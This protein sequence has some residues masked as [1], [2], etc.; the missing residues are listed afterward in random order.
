MYMYSE[1]RQTIA[2]N[3][4]VP[5]SRSDQNEII[6]YSDM[7]KVIPSQ[8]HELKTI[9]PDYLKFFDYVFSNNNASTYL[10]ILAGLMILGSSIL[11]DTISWKTF[12]PQIV[13]LSIINYLFCMLCDIYL[14][15]N[16]FRSFDFWYN[17]IIYI[18]DTV[19]RIVYRNG[20]SEYSLVVQ[21]L[22]CFSSLLSILLFGFCISICDCAPK[23]TLFMRRAAAFIITIYC[24]YSLVMSYFFLE[25]SNKEICIL[26]YSC[27]PVSSVVRS[28]KTSNIIFLIKLVFHIGWYPDTMFFIQSPTCVVPYVAQQVSQQVAPSQPVERTRRSSAALPAL[29]LTTINPIIVNKQSN[30]AVVHLSSNIESIFGKDRFRFKPLIKNP[31]TNLSKGYVVL[32]IATITYIINSVIWTWIPLNIS[33]PLIG[34]SYL[35]IVVFVV[36]IT[37]VTCFLRL[38]RTFDF[39]Y[40]ALNITSLFTLFTFYSEDYV[41]NYTIELAHIILTIMGGILSFFAM[42]STICMPNLHNYVKQIL[43]FFVIAYFVYQRVLIVLNQSKFRDI[44]IPFIMFDSSIPVKNVVANLLNII[45]IRLIK[46]AISYLTIPRVMPM[47]TSRIRIRVTM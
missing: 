6:L 14:L 45:I 19:L 3:Y 9:Q 4:V 13:I 5:E 43:I 1:R 2:A 18:I 11:I 31:F 47:I 10:T 29:E 36:S 42:G 41:D 7:K 22:I 15:K 16:L 25:I 39:L 37:D 27:A 35:F 23:T 46:I 34:V 21:I 33:L 8:D 12:I 44:N 26:L 17:I 32:I 28:L 20:F 30:Q 40:F 24:I 38:I